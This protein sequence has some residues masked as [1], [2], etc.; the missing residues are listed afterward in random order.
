VDR[1]EVVDAVEIDYTSNELAH[2]LSGILA[3]NGNFIERVLGP[4]PTAKKL[5]YVL[6]T[7]ATGIHALETG[8]I[9]PDLTRLMDAYGLSLAATLVERKRAGERAGL[10][11]GL[12][13]V[14]RPRVDRLL[15]R[16][17]EAHDSSFL[18]DEPRNEADVRRWL[19][20][21]RRRRLA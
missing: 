17:E 1:A 16:L 11:V 19:V 5:L 14:W 20:S 8:E 2:A 3:G 10:D 21:V 12:L 6:R 4:E 13:D 9:E 18:P 15:A 7:A